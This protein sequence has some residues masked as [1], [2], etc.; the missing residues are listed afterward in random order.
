MPFKMPQKEKL[1]NRLSIT[2]V[3]LVSALVLGGIAYYL[4]TIYPE[5]G[6]GPQQPIYF[7]HRVHAGVKEINCRFC[8]PN[9]ERSADAGI[10]T[11]EKCFYCHKYVIP[12]HPQL[13]KEKWH[14]DT[15]TPVPW[16]RIFYVPDFVKFKHFPH[17]NWGKLDCAECHGQV[18]HMDRLQNLEFKM[19]FCVQCHRRKNAQL[20]CWLACHH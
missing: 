14:L 11:V 8:H 5:R 15:N 7:S 9:V 4:F 12:Q 20:D 10:P 19:E 6:L 18:A 3:S 2:T 13:V 17:I 16:V 1:T